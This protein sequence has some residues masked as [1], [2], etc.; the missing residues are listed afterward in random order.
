MT[1]CC[2]FFINSYY[3]VD[4]NVCVAKFATKCIGRIATKH[5]SAAA[6]CLAFLMKLLR[7]DLGH[8]VACVFEAMKGNH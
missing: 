2:I 5:K 1:I 3:A 6:S 8:V 7:L 4:A